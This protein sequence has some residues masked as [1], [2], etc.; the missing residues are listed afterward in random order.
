RV[1]ALA[2]VTVRE[3]VRSRF[4]VSMLILLAAVNGLLPLLVQ[5]DGTAA[6][7]VEIMLRYTLGVSGVLL[8]VASLWLACGSIALDVQTRR[9]HHVL[10]KCVQ[11]VELWFGKWLGLVLLNAVLIAVSYLTVIGLLH[12][13]LARMDITDTER[14]MLHTHVLQPHERFLPQAETFGRQVDEH[15]QRLVDG[16]QILEGVRK[17]HVRETIERRIRAAR[18]VVGPGADRTWTLVVPD[19]IRSDRPVVLSL[20]LV[21][22]V[23]PVPKGE[24][25]WTIEEIGSLANAPPLISM[26]HPLYRESRVELPGGLLK[27][28][29]AYTV[30]FRNAMRQPSGQSIVFDSEMPV[31]F[32]QARG[33]FVSSYAAAMCMQILQLSALC[34]FGLLCGACFSFPVASFAA[35]AILGV[36]MIGHSVS[37]SLQRETG[38]H[39]HGQE[40]IGFTRVINLAG[41]VMIDISEKLVGPAFNRNPLPLLSRG[42][43]VRWGDVAGAAVVL[44]LVYGGLAAG[45]SCLVIRRRELVLASGEH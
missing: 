17:T 2:W 28:G 44:V 29:Q 19:N 34:A 10:T 6:G 24:G 25:R 23:G 3:A 1:A 27:S 5:G 7:M 20:T 42:V 32:L 35:G 13:R 18:S 45:L 16:D 21:P 30:R 38:I 36:A 33:H 43:R 39:A 26:T 41:E 15:F 37:Q 8:G 9:I 40:R 14:A 31:A 11:P 12:W 22:P 4:M